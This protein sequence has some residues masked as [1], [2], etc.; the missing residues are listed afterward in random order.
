MGGFTR[1]HLAHFRT[2]CHKFLKWHTTRADPQG[3]S[4]AANRRDLVSDHQKRQVTAKELQRLEKQ[5]KLAQTLRLKTEAEA[6]GED[7]ERK[8]AW[9]WSIEQ[10]ERWEAKQAESAAKGD[11]SFHSTY[12]SAP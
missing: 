4:S 10:N 9:E 6:N 11:S 7:T 12:P 3:Q 8:K 5:K 2:R 1:L